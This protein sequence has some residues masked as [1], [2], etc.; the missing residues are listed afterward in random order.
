MHG[1]PLPLYSA[2]KHRNRWTLFK[3][4][5][6]QSQFLLRDA[7]FVQTWRLNDITWCKFS[8]PAAVSEGVC[9]RTFVSHHHSIRPP[10]PP[11]THLPGFVQTDT[12]HLW[13]IGSLRNKCLILCGLFTFNGRVGWEKHL[14]C[15]H[16]RCDVWGHG[17]AVGTAPS[18][19]LEINLFEA[20]ARS[21]TAVFV[22]AKMC[23]IR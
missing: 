13:R 6:T 7:G 14:I 19:S 23:S 21:F 22:G 15:A 12:C 9:T 3:T 1:G 11:R 16:T 2:Y 20:A 5:C 18:R 4:H 8:L 17:N 10:I